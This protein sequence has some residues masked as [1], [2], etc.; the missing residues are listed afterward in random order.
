MN[1]ILNPNIF[2]IIITFILLRF[3]DSELFFKGVIFIIISITLIYL[4]QK[5]LNKINLSILAI[6]ILI[7]S[8]IN[9][10]KNIVET[11][12][13]LKINYQN[14]N[15][16]IELLGK[17][18]FSFIEDYY[19][20]YAE[21]CYL[22]TLDCFYNNDIRNNYLSPDQLVFNT[23][24]TYS[25]KVAEINFQNLADAR[26][27][28]INSSSGNVNYVNIFKLDTPYFV[29]YQNL[30]DLDSFCF[31]GLGYINTIDLKS[32]GLLHKENTCLN[33][34][35]KSF[36]GFNL[37]NNNLQISS[38]NNSYSKYFDEL[39]LLFFLIFLIFNLN[40]EKSYKKFKL[41]IPVLISTFI[42]FYISR[43]DNWFNVFNL[44]NFYFF[45][46][47]GGD[48]SFYINS[49]NILF[50]SFVNFKIF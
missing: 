10:K 47:E 18:R 49:T 36:T 29:E 26:M 13:P 48:G 17:D 7:F 21:E 44:F 28:F 11:S 16:Y 8:I 33:K 23:N 50:E 6:L 30:E 19:K 3:I 1:K 42:I 25:R 41:Y 12:G 2:F 27:S 39:V 5:K 34:A 43:F 15:Q 31:K 40:F 35:I 9:E 46:F 24:N 37:P 14:E 32:Y 38:S 22:N 45:G 20:N 4:P